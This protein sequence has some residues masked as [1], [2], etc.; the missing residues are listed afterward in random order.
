MSRHD[1]IDAWLM[2]TEE[3]GGG[4]LDRKKILAEREAKRRAKRFEEEQAIWKAQ[5]IVSGSEQ[6]TTT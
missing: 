2:N 4:P 5:Q 6:P 3:I 1:D